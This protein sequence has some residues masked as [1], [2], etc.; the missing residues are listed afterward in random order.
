MQIKNRKEI[1]L[2]LNDMPYYFISS[3][4]RLKNQKDYIMKPFISNSG[5]LM[6]KLWNKE[7]SRHVH[8]YIHRLVADTF[9][10]GI[11]ENMQ[12]NHIDG[13]KTNNFVGNLEWVTASENAR[14]AIRTGLHVPYQLPPHPHEGKRVR[15]IETG[16]EFNSLTECAN[17][18]GGFKT[19]ISA[20]LLGKVKSHLGYHFEE[21]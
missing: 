2:P 4:G 13:D 19:A 18:I 8:R 6:I 11:H 1:W 14:H 5:Y 12:V 20:C 7:E 17:H 10:D 15:I 9:F 16:E 3:L 21:I